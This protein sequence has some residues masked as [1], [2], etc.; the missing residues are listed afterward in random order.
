[1]EKGKS[2]KRGTPATEEAESKIVDQVNHEEW[3]CGVSRCS[4]SR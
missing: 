3:V 1:M 4:G 2:K